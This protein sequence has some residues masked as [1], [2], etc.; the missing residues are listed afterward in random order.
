MGKK[1]NREFLLILCFEITGN[2]CIAEAALNE[3]LI[4]LNLRD[5][6]NGSDEI[7][8]ASEPIPLGDVK[9]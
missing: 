1:F 7:R 9:W 2:I 5:L 4:Q 8:V 6:S 3:S